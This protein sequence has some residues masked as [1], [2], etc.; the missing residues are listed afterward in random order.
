[1][2]VSMPRAT[3][4]SLAA[5]GR[6]AI[7]SPHDLASE[8]G[9]D[10]L[11]SGGN[12][13]DAALAAAAALTVLLP[14]QCALGGDLVALVGLP[15]GTTHVLNGSGRSPA[16]VDAAG[17]R[18]AHLY[19][20]VDG[21]LPVT[22]PGVVDAWHELAAR[23]GTKSL[24][25]ALR[26]VADVARD[27]A[28]V[29]AGLARDL[30]LEARRI[31]RDPGMS[32]VLAPS[33][34]PLAEGQDLR[35]PRLAETLTA[36]A[37]GG[38]DAFYSGDVAASLVHTLRAHGSSM[39][40]DDL[41]A[42]TSTVES[43][44]VARF[45]DE[46]YL[47][48]GANTQGGFFL[49]ALRAVERLGR[50]LDPLGPDAGVL[51][52]IFAALSAARDAQLGDP[53]TAPSLDGAAIEDLALRASQGEPRRRVPHG[54]KPGGDTVAVVAADGAGTWVSLIQS[55]F[56]AFGAALLDPAT[57]V[58]FHNRGAAFNLAPGSAAELGGGRRPP[59]SLMPV[60][61]KD[62]ASGRTIGAHGT[63][64]GR[65]QFQIHTHLALHLD[66]GRSPAEA[67]SS[68]RWLHG[69]M[70][71]GAAEQAVVQYE[72]DVAEA[73]RTSLAR[74]GD[75][76]RALPARSD[77]VGHSHVIR[78]MGEGLDVAT[79]PRA[80]GSALTDGS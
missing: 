13:V 5:S 70:G 34:T 66:L 35:Q 29:S 8:L 4:R 2:G 41:D 77:D 24:A 10:V 67:V 54:P 12:A 20:P 80:D 73:A 33:G 57:G 42:H 40:S 56:H 6:W 65:A 76:A 55:V 27:G 22:V 64:G 36:I 52:G 47:S 31:L 9:A 63:M 43:P 7:A 53:L 16:A 21:A 25:P 78:R 49:A 46:D 44:L 58:L 11:R 62:G 17:L 1:M 72:Q 48:G 14:N 74:T 45:G 3:T 75:A 28:P 61:V 19:L 23:W 15:D 39:T 38:R 51:Y 32:E 59:H 71:A 50:P 68:P 26:N 60:L 79:D 37:D 69:H 18:A 30:A